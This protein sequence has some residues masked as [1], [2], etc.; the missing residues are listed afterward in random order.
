MNIAA[1]TASEYTESAQFLCMEI[2]E[3]VMIARDLYIYIY[4]FSRGLKLKSS[5]LDGICFECLK[6]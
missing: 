3:G 1:E 2:R 6:S 4:I 5:L